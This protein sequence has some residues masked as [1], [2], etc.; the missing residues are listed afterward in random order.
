MLRSVLLSVAALAATACTNQ[1]AGTAVPQSPENGS[2]PS[3]SVSASELLLSIESIRAI[4]GGGDELSVIPTMDT[5]SPVDIEPL[6]DTTPA[7]CAVVFAETA[8]FGRTWTGFHKT[9]YQYPPESGIISQAAAI[10][11]DDDEAQRAFR[12]LSSTLFTCGATEFGSVYLGEA[13]DA[14][15]SVSTRPAGDCGRDYRLVSSVLIEVTFCGFPESVSEIV[16]ANIADNV[17]G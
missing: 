13:S 9:T 4:T 8:V 5:S 2:V 15:N 3:T 6:V 1:I 12:T 7:E 16:I 11:P 17:P 14:E 10:Y